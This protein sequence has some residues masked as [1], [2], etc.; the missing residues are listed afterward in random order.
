MRKQPI[1]ILTEDLNFFYVLKK[2]LDKHNIKFQILNLDAKIP[3]ISSIIL[4]TS[5]D[6][7]KLK[8]GPHN[9]Y[10]VYSK[11]HDF[12]KYL[13]KVIAAYRIKYKENYSTLTFSIDPGKRLGLMIFLDDFYLESYCCLEKNVLLKFINK[14]IE[15]FQDDNPS[16][17]DINFKL[18][19]GVLTI[20]FDLVKEIYSLFHDRN[21]LKVHLIDEF[22]SSKIRLSREK[23]YR[24]ISKD[25]ISAL[26][27]AFR[28]GITV[29][30][31]NY[32]YIFEQIKN[33]SLKTDDFNTL[34]TNNHEDYL[35]DLKEVIEKVLNGEINLSSAMEM[36]SNNK[37]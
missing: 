7:D 25:E 35:L 2:E 3:T 11:N 22:R 28:N 8:V 18:G 12:E 30:Q 14:H 5:E 16:L 23:G 31:D 17:I 9:T 34:K 24:K 29:D 20:A 21:N 10:L 6:F 15:T 13:I 26:I 37:T 33:K 27:L 32:E 4:T 36:L 1:Y 19:R